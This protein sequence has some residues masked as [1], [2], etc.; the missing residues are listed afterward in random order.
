MSLTHSISVQNLKS[1][2]TWNFTQER[3]LAKVLA[4]V[5]QDKPLSK[6]KAIIISKA[7]VTTWTFRPEERNLHRIWGEDP[8]PPV[9]AKDEELSM[10]LP[11]PFHFHLFPPSPFLFPFIFFSTLKTSNFALGM[12]RMKCHLPIKR[13]RRESH[14]SHYTQVL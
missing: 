13:D 3:P 11:V 12:S 2:L 8:P 4:I 5:S 7:T 10:H 1:F 9:C 14:A 6:S